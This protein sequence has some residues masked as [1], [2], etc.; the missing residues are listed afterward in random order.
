[1]L[2]EGLSSLRGLSGGSEAD[3]PL[4]TRETRPFCHP[5]AMV[6]E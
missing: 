5:G 4:P 3:G 2:P 1:M 6:L